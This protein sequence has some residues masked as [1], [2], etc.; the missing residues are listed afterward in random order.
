MNASER[1]EPTD[2]DYDALARDV[3][4]ALRGKRSQA[5]FSRRLGYTSNVAYTWESGRRFPT[6][7]ETLRAASRVGVDVRAALLAFLRTLPEELET[8]DPTSP[9]CVAA[10]LRELRGPAPMERLAERTGVSRSAISRL[11]AGKTEPRLPLFLRL[12]DVVSRRVLDL[13]A[14]F[15]D[16]EA[17][18][19]AR[20][21]W[22][23]LQ[24]I[25]RLSAANP[26]FELV[27]RA[28]ELDSYTR[29]VP[30]W[31]AERLGIS[32]EDEERTLRELAAA[33]L[34]RWDGAR[35]QPDRERSID[36][37]RFERTAA[38]SLRAHWAEMAADRIRAD[39]EAGAFA[40]LV[41]TTD[42]ATLAA[43]REL[44][45]G[46]FRAFRALVASSPTNTRVAVANMHVLT[47]DDGG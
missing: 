16:L 11:L 34:I 31:I 21:E 23:R 30:G 6:A 42:D 17:V 14:G 24:N 35:W 9:A 46:Y 10:L 36:T 43:L 2:I 40:Y 5:A 25:R 33:G 27:P 29:H 28:L 1:A 13:L 7:A 26:L 32:R 4:R 3:L 8:I 47:I 12:V 38:A 44:Q 37:T 18:P 15:V 22:S 39:P 45:L 20:E 41:F 19:A